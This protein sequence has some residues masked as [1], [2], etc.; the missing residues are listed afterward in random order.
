MPLTDHNQV[1][2]EGNLPN[3]GHIS[4]EKIEVH[5]ETASIELKELLGETEYSNY[6]SA[7]SD[8]AERKVLSKAE[9]LLTLYYAVPVMNIETQGTGIVRSKG[10]DESR[11]EMISWNE[12]KSL[13]EMFRDRAMKLIQ[14]YLPEKDN[15]QSDDI[16]WAS[17]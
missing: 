1:R 2:K 17:I 6:E 13:A 9:A 10:W 11:S 4:K 16:K 14:P 8:E 5:I 3:E 12:A 15:P 7:A